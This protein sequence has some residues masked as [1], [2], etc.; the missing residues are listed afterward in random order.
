MAISVQAPRVRFT[1]HDARAFSDTVQEQ[2]LLLESEQFGTD[3]YLD[4]VI[5]KPWGHEYRVYA[6]NFY[7]IWKLLL[8]PG[9]ST[10]MHCHPRKE[11]A[12]LCLRGLGKVRFLGESHV[13]QAMDFIHI[14]KG[15][16]HATDNIGP[17]E[18]EL[19]EVESPRNKLDLIRLADRYGRQGKSYEREPLQIDYPIHPGNL[20]RG[21]KLRRHCVQQRYQF[22]L[23]AGL[24]LLCRP[25]DSLL[26]FVSL[27]VQDAIE[28]SIQ[29]F[30]RT[31]AYNEHIDLE[32]LYFT[33]S[34]YH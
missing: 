24:D 25:E 29:V 15:V 2:D 11:T 7:D 9:Q 8:L 27:S 33:I 34:Q 21:S 12:L 31:L 19:I 10:S 18:L 28:H 26:F 30:P 5:E 3:T 23:R 16:W 17:N 22:G 14:G 4:Q 20:V 6:D 13:I 32:K 1:H